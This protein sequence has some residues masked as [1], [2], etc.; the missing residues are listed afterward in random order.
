[1]KLSKREKVLLYIL[2]LVVIIAGSIY[3]LLVPAM[4]KV[5]LAEEQVTSARIVMDE[6]KVTVM[7]ADSVTEEIADHAA[8]LL[9]YKDY[10]LPYLFNEEV[11]KR[12]TSMLN[13]RGLTPVRMEI[14]AVTEAKVDP[15]GTKPS[16]ESAKTEENTAENSGITTVY[17]GGITVD[18]KGTEAGFQAFLED[19]SRFPA[20][21]VAEYSFDRA[22]KPGKYTLT[23]EY[24]MLP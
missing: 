8:E 15:Y 18:V 10:F 16:E 22:N 14:D 12:I 17:T 5:T 1:M 19:I 9:G 21:R 4:E 24:F 23:M 2:L 20:I 6:M 3:L 13:R 7:R 11:D